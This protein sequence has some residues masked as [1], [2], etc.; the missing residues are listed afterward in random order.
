MKFF[1]R[2]KPAAAP[3]E[4]ADDKASQPKPDLATPVPAAAEPPLS[5]ELTPPGTPEAVKTVEPARLDTPSAV[6]PAEAPPEHAS[7]QLDDFAGKAP[8]SAVAAVPEPG[9]AKPAPEPVLD[10]SSALAVSAATPPADLPPEDGFFTR[11]RRGLSRTSDSLFSGLGNLFLGK[12]EIDAELLEE[13][14]SRLLMADVGVDAT[15]DIIQR[16]T[17]RVSRKEL[18]HPEALQGALREECCKY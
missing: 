7:V 12:K 17:H 6:K 5:V 1:K 11:I 13:L 14:E 10:S 4:A 16:L 3:L 8:I 9:D 15:T 18:T 2:K